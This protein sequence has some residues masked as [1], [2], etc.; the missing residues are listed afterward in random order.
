M[1]HSCHKC[2]H[3]VE[4]GKA[5]CAQCGAP[6]I[7]V[8]IPDTPPE[9]A[10]LSGQVL[11]VLIHEAGPSLPVVP[12]N[13]LLVSWSH[14]VRPCAL[15]AGVAALLM[16]L[17]LN[18]FIGALAAGFLAAT[19]S[20]RRVSAT[21]LRP[22]A[23]SRLGAFSGLLLFGISTIIEMLAVALLHKGPEIRTAMMEKVQQA[24]ARYPG[25]D[26]QP[27]LD[28]VKSPNGFAFMLVASL[29]FGLVAFMILGGLGGALCA[30]FSG[31]RKRP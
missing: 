20:Q 18:P 26:A 7:R 10:L 22:A 19:F 3:S 6:Q 29:I 4:D 1:D 13:P 5:F 8:I 30:A 27:F 2:G 21:E 14:A 28:F 31:R 25:P 9:P 15:G 24:A 11:P 23:G 17:G 12:T 16:V